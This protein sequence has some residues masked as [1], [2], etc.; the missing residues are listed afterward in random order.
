MEYRMDAEWNVG[1]NMKLENECY[2]A[3]TMELSTER[4]V[5]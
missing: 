4:N 1:K 2:A 3:W 5:E